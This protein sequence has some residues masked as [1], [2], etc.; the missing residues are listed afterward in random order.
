[1]TLQTVTITTIS[2]LIC[3]TRACDEPKLS[4]TTREEQPKFQSIKST[5]NSTQSLV[6]DPEATKSTTENQLDAPFTASSDTTRQSGKSSLR[7]RPQRKA[8]SICDRKVIINPCFI[9]ISYRF[10]D[11][12]KYIL[13]IVSGQNPPQRLF[14]AALQTPGAMFVDDLATRLLIIRPG[15]AQ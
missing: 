2:Y 4:K 15:A 5:R 1:M 14:L 10:F 3:R 11:V 7:R 8:H 13:S 12:S 6:K 9:F